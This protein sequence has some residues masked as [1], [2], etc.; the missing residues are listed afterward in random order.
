L[1]IRFKRKAAVFQQKLKVP[2][3]H[4]VKQPAKHFV[5]DSF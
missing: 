2:V 4:A 5:V 1:N 3:L